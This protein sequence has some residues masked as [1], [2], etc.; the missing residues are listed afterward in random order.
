LAIELQGL[1]DL[2]FEAELTGF[3]TAEI[4]LILTDWQ[5]ASLQTTAPEDEKL[6]LG[7]HGRTGRTFGNMPG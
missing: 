6:E 1:I 5:Q 7:R 2:G 4:D 3:E